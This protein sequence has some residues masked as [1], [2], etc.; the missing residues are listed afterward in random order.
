M[1]K[2]K[3]TT[4]LVGALVI[5][6]SAMAEV[7]GSITQTFRMVSDET[8]NA[9]GQDSTQMLGKELN[10]TF[11]NSVDLDNGMKASLSGKYEDENASSDGD[12]EYQLKISG[13]MAYVA[14]G[15][16]IGNDGRMLATPQIGYA[17]NSYAAMI[18]TDADGISGATD[19]LGTTATSAD[20]IQVGANI[21]NGSVFVTYQPQTGSDAED[22]GNPTAKDKGSVTGFGYT[23]KPI[24]GLT[25]NIARDVKTAAMDN[26]NEE[27]HDKY[28]A[29]YT[30]GQA[31]VGFDIA[32]LDVD[33]G[34]TTDLERKQYGIKYA[35]SD[36]V[37][38][39]LSYAE[40]EHG[41]TSAKDEEST[42]LEVGYNLGGM[43]ITLAYAQLEN[44]DG[45]DGGDSEG[46]I[47][48][49]GLNF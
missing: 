12:I 42:V 11:K 14:F 3:T 31:V 39:A 32:E 26:N 20:Y 44:A 16:D 24:D 4:A 47:L 5:G 19:A 21:A 6:G 37:S 9:V 1:N 33:G 45:T 27:T 18:T 15:S 28:G 30:F 25:V 35:V 41:A 22:A 7:G 10:F 34:D 23:G 40:T 46:L 29:S 43:G 8:K 17:N 49:T 2:L 48:K 38:V 36:Q 13:D